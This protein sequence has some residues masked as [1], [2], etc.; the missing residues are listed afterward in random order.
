MPLN[1]QIDYVQRLAADLENGRLGN[2][3]ELSTAITRYYM[4]S[5]T[6]GAPLGLPPTLPAPA[7]QGAPGPVGP[8]TPPF[9]QPRE[10]LFKNT[11]KAYFL[12]KEVAQG[13][14]NVQDLLQAYKQTILKARKLKNDITTTIT[15]IQQIDDEIRELVR[16]LRELGP[17]I[18]SF[19]QDKVNLIR[20]QARVFESVFNL[21]QALEGQNLDAEDF[22]RAFA[23]ELSII[24]FFTNFKP[25][26][27]LSAYREVFFFATKAD[28]TIK[29]LRNSVS[30][31]SN[32]KFLF[33]SKLRKLLQDIISA[34]SGFLQPESY[35]AFWK[36]LLYIPKYR[37]L[38]VTV[39]TFI[40]NNRALKEKKR[41]LLV[42]LKNK[43]VELETRL[44]AKIQQLKATIQ[45]RIEETGKKSQR[46]LKTYVAAV[47]TVRQTERE[48]RLQIKLVKEQIAL[49]GQ[50]FKDTVA[51]IA[52]VD[53]VITGAN[54]LLDQWRDQ[55][56]DIKAKYAGIANSPTEPFSAN[57]ILT[58][59]KIELPQLR[60]LITSLL[61]SYQIVSTDVCK[62]I[63]R[64]QLRKLDGLISTILSIVEVD[65]P[66]LMD[67]IE[68]VRL[69]IQIKLEITRS[70]KPK[71]SD[72][73]L[74]TKL[75]QKLQ[76]FLSKIAA[77]VKAFIKK[78]TDK[79]K[80]KLEKAKLAVR[81]YIEELTD[82]SSIGI[83][84]KNTKRKVNDFKVSK[85]KEIR[86]IKLLYSKL[87][88]LAKIT[89]AAG[90]IFAN[91]AQKRYAITDNERDLKSVFSNWLKFQR[92]ENNKTDE[93]V[94]TEQAAFFRR[95][96]ELKIYEL[97]VKFF[98]QA[99]TEFKNNNLGQS[100]KDFANRQTAYIG[101]KAKQSLELVTSFIQNPPTKI[102]LDIL[103]QLSLD[104]LN[105][106]G[107]FN[108]LC[109]SERLV[110]KKL[111]LGIETLANQIPPD[112]TDP[113]LIAIKSGL[114]KASSVFVFLLKL[115]QKAL[116]Q[117][118]EFIAKTVKRIEASVKKRIDRIKEKQVQDKQQRAKKKI[119]KEVNPE[120]KAMGLMF[121]LA[122][123]LFW[124]GAN[125]TT[126]TGTTIVVTSVG[127]FGSIKIKPENGA[128]G[129]ASETG[130]NFDKQVRTVKGFYTNVG[131]GIAPIQFVGYA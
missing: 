86:E 22:R 110:S 65:I 122:A 18:K 112:T 70:K 24:E 26:L 42:K 29:S 94:A 51:L 90:R 25:T 88:L 5:I 69:P 124:I 23:E 52:K 128:Q 117:V 62:E 50:I 106:K 35:I 96:D 45:K 4:R 64:T 59:Y 104:F 55:I 47:R 129:F 102:N 87:N 125:W 43:R 36:E 77:K 54:G 113:I 116:K 3:E 109:L 123:K 48:I 108:Q 72:L 91:I 101:P 93:Q 127:R 19:I 60:L 44:Q 46:Q 13:K 114:K 126:P 7:L 31:E 67:K 9:T 73:N 83:K 130:L 41:V 27:N 10:K 120:A 1:F 107:M 111:S 14:G 34:I 74:F 79:I 89:A 17:S 68:R 97:L 95:I 57:L 2:A 71:K 92:L 33:Y 76:K 16:L 131:L 75:I 121:G 118:S 103:N 98:K 81:A 39:T 20:D 99:I 49:L 82:K 58:T 28:R 100:L 6:N 32:R 12:A 15:E 61:D 63:F 38:A 30:S 8:A 105:I 80:V 56:D 53:A 11:V 40:N 119:E 84:V 66:S 78:L 115:V 85:E 21:P 37:G